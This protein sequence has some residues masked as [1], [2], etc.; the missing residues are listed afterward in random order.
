MSNAYALLAIILSALATLFLRALPFALLGTRKAVPE[1]IKYLGQTLPSAIM[2]VLIIY[3]LKD[4]PDNSPAS[5]AE[6]LIAVAVCA[7]IHLWKNN[8]LL[9]IFA[10]TLLY[11]LLCMV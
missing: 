9:S 3:C 6:K 2:A 5:G 1:K 8:T 4:I 7:I 11:M 10:S